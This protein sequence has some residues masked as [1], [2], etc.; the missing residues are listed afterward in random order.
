MTQ[1]QNQNNR[2]ENKPDQPE[3]IKIKEVIVVEGRDDTQAV[4]RAVNGLTIETHGFGIRRE[5]WS[6]IAKAYE[7]KGI[8]IFTDPDHAG[9]EI[10]RKLTEKFPNAK[11][12]Y[13]SRVYATKKGDIGIE[14]AEPQ[15][16]IEA[17]GKACCTIQSN[18]A[19]P[20]YTNDDLF[21][22]GLAGQSDSKE[23]REKLGEVLGIGYGN[24][25]GLLKK[26]NQFNINREDFYEALRTIDNQR[27]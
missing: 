9:E 2:Y 25:K 17:L 22:A 13:L 7:E 20:A 23:R 16:I 21:A 11:Q 18:S 24:A 3:K 19:E 15:A 27:D 8:I 10:R 6:L 1:N 14:N 5:T 26:L 12:A 4:N